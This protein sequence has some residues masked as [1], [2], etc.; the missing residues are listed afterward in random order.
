MSIKDKETGR[1]INKDF[2][3]VA[4]GGDMNCYGVARA[5]YEAYGLKTVLLGKERVFPTSRSTLFSDRLYD[6]RLLDDDVL[7][8]L[9]TEVDDKYRGVKKF[10]FATNDDYVR[11]IIHNKAAIEA[12]S[13]DFIV[14]VI[15][16][17]LFE[18]LDN[19]DT[20]YDMCEQYGLPYPRS[21]VF[22]FS[23]DS[24][25]DFIYQLANGQGRMRGTR[26]RASSSPAGVSPSR[27]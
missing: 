17:Q 26:S 23:K 14:P 16:E 18:R 1:I 9:L 19:K 12:I 4:L 24:L 3:A 5:F 25:E 11:H 2:I 20:F 10:V 22:D 6:E 27:S 21:T 8:K 13:S 7:I 15:S